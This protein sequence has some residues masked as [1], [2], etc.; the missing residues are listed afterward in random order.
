[1]NW[2]FLTDNSG[3]D[4]PWPADG[5][6]HRDTDLVDERGQRIGF[7]I[8]RS[9]VNPPRQ[10]VPPF[11]RWVSVT[12]DGEW[13]RND[14]GTFHT[15]EEAAEAWV[16]QRIRTAIARYRRLEAERGTDAFD[17]SRPRI[18][19]G[20]R[21]PTPKKKTKTFIESLDDAQRGLDGCAKQLRGCGCLL[22]MLGLLGL[23]PF[24]LALL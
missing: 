12:K 7:L 6:E 21:R 24:L 22:I 10:G 18:N 17:F 23:A 16:E 1:M 2:D 11:A 20:R 15:T 14:G 4:S 9:T 8:E 3:E 5:Q 19:T 13:I